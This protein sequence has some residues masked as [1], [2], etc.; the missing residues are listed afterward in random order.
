MTSRNEFLLQNK[1]PRKATFMTA[2]Y[3][4]RP[5]DEIGEKIVDVYICKI[6]KK[7][8]PM[9]IEIETSWGKGYLLRDDTKEKLKEL[10]A[11]A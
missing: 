3:S 5:E 10:M 7:L 4:L 6:R 8:S 1:A 11:I 2:L 9:G